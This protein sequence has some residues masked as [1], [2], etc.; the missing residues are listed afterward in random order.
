MVDITLFA[1][2]PSLIF[3]CLSGALSIL[4]SV[5]S[6][7]FQNGPSPTCSRKE[8]GASKILIL[9]LPH[10]RSQ[11]S[12]DNAT[13]AGDPLVRFQ[14]QSGRF[15]QSQMS[16]Q[17]TLRQVVQVQHVPL[18]S[19]HVSLVGEARVLHLVSRRRSLEALEQ[20]VRS[21]RGHPRIV[22]PVREKNRTRE[23][24]GAKRRRRSLGRG[25]VVRHLR[26]V[27]PTPVSGHGLP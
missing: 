14:T 23:V 27:H 11:R 21:R 10:G 16:T 24:V 25:D 15:R 7:F 4:A 26:P 18:L 8:A 2:L 20:F 17:K 19:N 22:R 1:P 12:G 6:T 5:C 13:L 3:A 9:S